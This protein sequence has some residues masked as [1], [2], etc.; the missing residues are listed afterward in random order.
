MQAW[1]PQ[2]KVCSGPSI[3]APLLR[4][5]ATEV[6]MHGCPVTLV[7]AKLRSVCAWSGYDALEARAASTYE[8]WGQSGYVFRRSDNADGHLDA[9]RFSW[10][11]A[12]T[13][14]GV[15]AAVAVDF[16]VLAPDGRI[17]LRY[18]FLDTLPPS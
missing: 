5:L 8:K 3:L 1:R 14:G 17:H 18:Q 13:G 6:E 16:L 9:V 11:R 2:M 12:P 7:I 15:A 4:A 10:E